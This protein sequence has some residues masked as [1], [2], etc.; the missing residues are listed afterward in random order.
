MDFL[1]LTTE[2]WTNVGIS[3]LIIVATAIFARPLISLL[4]DRIIRRFT[5]RTNTN[6]DDA[7]LDAVRGPLYW[8]VVFLGVN[9]ALDR[10]NFISEAINL[11]LSDFYFVVYA[12]LVILIGW[13]LVSKVTNWYTTDIAPRTESNLDEQ[14]M[15]LIRRV[16]LMLVLV[17]GA[18]VILGHFNVEVSGLVATLGIGSLAIALAAQEALTD[19]I[20]GILILVDRPFSIGDRI[21]ILDLDTWGDV[22]DIGL[23][24]TR[25]RTRDFRM[26][27]VPNSVISKN[28][29]VNYSSP[30]PEYRLQIEIG[31]GYG[32]D[33]EQVREILVNAVR[34]VE[35][36]LAD[37][38]V[39][40]LFLQFGDS[41]LVFRVRW[42]LDS[43]EDTRRMFDRVNTAMYAALRAADVE[44]PFPQ[45]DVYHKVTPEDGEQIA[46]IFRGDA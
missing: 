10:I 3:A 17:L 12:L 25:I 45:R 41:A 35:G 44:I 26:V 28:L 31:V 36:V 22:V 2:Q 4:L 18:I 46:R 30:S 33:V 8:M 43:Y 29:I 5:N 37:K 15:P 16:L 1:G 20:G 39:E 40:A 21:E 6:L 7:I 38:P 9:I 42:W 23:R 19:T 24:S 32:S 27:I 14:L 34:D 13:R 11:E